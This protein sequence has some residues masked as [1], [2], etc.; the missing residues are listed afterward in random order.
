MLPNSS[1]QNF[2]VCFTNVVNPITVAAKPALEHLGISTENVVFFENDCLYP[3]DLLNSQVKSAY[4][5]GPSKIQKA[6][7][8]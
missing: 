2:I 5:N 1:K 4:P 6:M 3:Y 8:D 7:I